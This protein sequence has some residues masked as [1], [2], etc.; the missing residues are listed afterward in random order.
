MRGSLQTPCLAITREFVKMQI[1]GSPHPDP[2][3]KMIVDE[4]L[5]SAFSTAPPD[6]TCAAWSLGATAL[7][8]QLGLMTCVETGH[9]LAPGAAGSVWFGKRGRGPSWSR[10]V[11]PERSPRKPYTAANIRPPTPAW[12][13]THTHTPRPVPSIINTPQ[14]RHRS[15]LGPAL[16]PL[17]DSLS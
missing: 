1:P 14:C 3:A 5:E 8:P 2:L 9:C 17:N 10:H 11:D 6:N 16:C 4:T 13:H 15:W 12:P 7:S